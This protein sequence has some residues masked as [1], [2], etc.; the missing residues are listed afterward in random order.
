MLTSYID[1]VKNITEG[2]ETWEHTLRLLSLQLSLHLS[3]LL[4]LALVLVNSLNMDE[5]NGESK[6]R[7]LQSQTAERSL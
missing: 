6:L 2:T 3:A 5:D 1:C 7:H 4:V